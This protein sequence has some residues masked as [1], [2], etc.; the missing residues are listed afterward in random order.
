MRIMAVA[1]WVVAWGLALS[2]PAQAQDLTFSDVFA[3][4]V[5]IDRT[6]GRVFLEQSVFRGQFTYD[7]DMKYGNNNRISYRSNSIGNEYRPLLG[8]YSE[9]IIDGD[10]NFFFDVYGFSDRPAGGC[11]SFSEADNK[12]RE[13]GWGAGDRSAD[14]MPPIGSGGE[15]IVAYYQKS[16]MTFRVSNFEYTQPILEPWDK[17][18]TIREAFDR[19]DKQRAERLKIKPGSDAYKALCLTSAEVTFKR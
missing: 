6:A 18:E 2:A 17:E 16:G 11:V 3:A 12:L 14:S 1:A 19:A 8:S 10:V 5:K 15:D 7:N 4:F 13:A 9:V